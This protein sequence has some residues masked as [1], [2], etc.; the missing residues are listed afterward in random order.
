MRSEKSQPKPQEQPLAVEE[1]AELAQL[2]GDPNVQ[3]YLRLQESIGSV[4]LGVPLGVDLVA[5]QEA[6]SIA[7]AA[8]IKKLQKLDSEVRVKAEKFLALQRRAELS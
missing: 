5:L 4:S 6:R 8:E 7:I 1:R 2:A 3:A